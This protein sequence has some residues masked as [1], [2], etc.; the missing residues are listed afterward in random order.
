VHAATCD[1]LL[2]RVAM[3][4]CGY[5]HPAA[6]QHDKKKSG[7]FVARSFFIAEQR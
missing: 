7:P 3:M 1:L 2:S 6:N 4:A 5:Q